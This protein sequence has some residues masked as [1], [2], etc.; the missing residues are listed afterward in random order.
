MIGFGSERIEGELV[1]Y[2]IVQNSHGEGWGKEGY[3]KFNIDIMCGTDKRLIDGGFA[4][5]KIKQ[6]G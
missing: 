3:A 1:H 2:W 5:H 6:G 4:P